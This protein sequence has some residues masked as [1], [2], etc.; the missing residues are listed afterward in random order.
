MQ[1]LSGLHFY[2]DN[3]VDLANVNSVGLSLQKETDAILQW[4]RPN[5][6]SSLVH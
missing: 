3:C 6:T 4:G 2:R 5:L 1:A